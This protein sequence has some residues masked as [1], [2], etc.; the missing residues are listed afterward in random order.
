MT[1]STLTKTDPQRLSAVVVALGKILNGNVQ[2]V[3]DFMHLDFGCSV[4]P[5]VPKSM[6]T[7]NLHPMSSTQQAEQASFTHE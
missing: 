6:L 4:P 5:G 7:Q 1:S 3:T 2:D